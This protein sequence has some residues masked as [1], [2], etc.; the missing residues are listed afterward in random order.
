MTSTSAPLDD[1]FFAD[2]LTRSTRQDVPESARL[3]AR[4][5]LLDSIGVGLGTL[6]HPAVAV[7]RA[8]VDR[9]LA[10]DGPAVIWGSGRSGDVEAALLANTV[11]L[12]CYDYNDV[13]HGRTGQAGHPSDVVPGLIAAAEEAGATGRALVDAV[14][15]T[16]DAAT[17]LFD[18][19]NVTEHGWDYAN[20]T[21]LASVTG[22]ASLLRLTPNQTAEALGIFGATHIATNQLESGD[23]SASGN[24][25]M[26][27][28]FNGADAVLAA[29][30]ACRLAAV[31]AEAP[32]FSLAGGDGFFA[33]QVGPLMRS[34]EEMSAIARLD[35]HGVELTE[36]K[37]WPVG[38]RA[39]AAISAALDCRRRIAP[40]EQI[41][42]VRVHAEAGV[43]DHMV[44]AE[45]WKPHSRETADHSL[46]FIVAV[47]LLEGDVTIDHFNTEDYI[48]SPAVRGLLERITVH[49]RPRAGS[50]GRSSFPT[51]VEVQIEGGALLTSE[52]SYPP[53]DI[54]ALPFRDTL[55]EKFRA[56]A[57]RALPAGTVAEVESAVGGLDELADVCELTTLLRGGEAAQA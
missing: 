37:R 42:A 9:Y 10:D 50:G 18:L 6:D 49:E 16:Y 48:A 3:A 22:F 19:V 57:A 4:L 35:R 25:T 15:T 51:T 32:S 54:R 52:G 5:V 55:S 20:L 28:R 14:V 13:L 33:R 53:E 36:F 11:P 47:A 43:L 56:L 21:G 2:L 40:P 45:A 46:P 44:R 12:R 27:K 1:R 41:A 17:V 31:G 30:R 29:L 23:L 8:Y 24:L 7:A 38:T 26:W 34:P 39:Q